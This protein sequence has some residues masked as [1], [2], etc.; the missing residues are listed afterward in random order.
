MAITI[1]FKS[2]VLNAYAV[3]AGEKPGSAALG[4]HLAYIQSPGVGVT[5][6]KAALE[7]YFSTTSTATM[8]ASLLANLGLSPAFTQ[9]QAEAFLTAAGSNRVGAMMDL[10]TALYSY[11]GTDAAL[12]TA[13]TSYQAKIMASDVYSSNSMNKYGEAI[14]TSAGQTIA[15]TTG[16]D[17]LMGTAMAD[18]FLG[19]SVGNA[20]TL[21]DGD[22][23][24]GGA[25]TDTLIVDFLSQGN[26]IT[27]VLSNIETVVI[28]A[29][30][31]GSDANGTGATTDGNNQLSGQT[32]Q[33]DAQRSV[34]VDSMDKVTAAAGV[35]R[36]ESNNSRS[37]VIVEDVRIGNSQKTKDVTIAMVETDPGNVD[38]G[39]YF[40]QLSLRNSGGG[41]STLTI[42]VI[43]TGAANTDSTKPL[44]NNPY[45]TFKIGVNGVLQSINLNPTGNTTAAAG[46]DT[47]AALLAL[48]QASLA[49]GGA[50]TA[51]LGSTFSVVDPLSGNTVTGTD[52]ILTGAAGMVFT[53]VTGSGWVN[54]TGAAVPNNSNIYTFFDTGS[55]TVTELVTST[56]VLDDV[57]RGSTGGDL[58]VG[59]M[60]VG[61]T[62]TSRGVE[63]F[64][65][66]VHDNSKLQTITSTNN[67]LREVTIVNG[68]TSS[69]V[70]DAY[71]TTVTNAGNL[72][73]NG[74][75]ENG[76]TALIGTATGA[77]VG[78]S[79]AG[80]AGFTDVRLID[81]T[82]MTGKLA[83]T[84][85]VT[86][87]SIA[88][89]I[90]LVD[91][92]SSPTADV[93]G[94]GN[95][96]HNIPG[97]NFIYTGGTNND[98]MVVNVDSAVA[99]SRSS[100]L[101]GQSDFTFNVSG[102]AGN[103]AITFNLIDS[104]NNALL[105]NAEAWY[106]NQ[107]LNANITINGDAGNDTIRTPGAGN[108]IIN[109]DAGND[110]IY[111]DNRV[112][113]NKPLLPLL[114]PIQM[115]VGCTTRQI[116]RRLCT[117]HGIARIRFPAP[118]LLT[119]C[120]AQ[121]PQ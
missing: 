24:D 113:H 7:A 6:Y 118:T 30:S 73:V 38:F 115:H 87:D 41:T 5:G 36:W 112:R 59:G 75:V 105:G 82:T 92:A 109:G 55:T 85:D 60:S 94:A 89:Y 12:L 98:T 100:V 108:K 119:L 27:P 66:T 47:Y 70:A 69:A 8:A 37:D 32:V 71:T 4:E 79:A 42:R 28:R 95:V 77:S 86:T 13:K 11:N 14:N 103:D 54:T 64:E 80:A 78:H 93:A 20:N 9:A 88:K 114:L 34:A 76:D 53:T 16:F 102:G 104:S 10:A 23:L 15:L 26:A 1:G 63:R 120:M 52:I 91:T 48:F 67:A 110:V 21:T 90:T 84:A 29:Q 56:I 96:N 44:L 107:V 31:A 50:A 72:T 43:D 2:I 99:A 61:T 111:T 117:W 116:K 51:A 57:G 40:D 35:T 46:A 17:S 25:G 3:L 33:I 22:R 65:I 68:A 101:S 39:V 97:A 18:T 106:T 58:V 74:T 121:P 62:S 49:P 45:D 81:G 19:R 83:F